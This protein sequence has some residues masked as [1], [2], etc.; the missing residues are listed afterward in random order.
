MLGF[1]LYNR[2]LK[3]VQVPSWNKRPAEVPTWRSMME[4]GTQHPASQLLL[5]SLCL[6]PS[7]AHAG[8]EY[9]LPR[10][11]VAKVS[12][13]GGLTTADVY[14]LTVLRGGRSLK[15]RCQQGHASAEG[16]EDDASLPLSFQMAAG[17]IFV[18]MDILPSSLCFS[19]CVFSFSYKDSSHIGLSVHPNPA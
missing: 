4:G 8:S 12:Q 15:S 1:C 2:S 13:P 17:L 3:F 7:L 16:L 11:T 18:S 6:D 9:Q 10:A 19:L 5:S 14:C